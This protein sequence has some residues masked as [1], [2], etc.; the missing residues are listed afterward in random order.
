MS[1]K[2]IS[3]S[4]SNLLS[5]EYDNFVSV[6]LKIILGEKEYTDNESLDVSQLVNE[7][8]T[9][10]EKCSTSCPNVFDWLNAFEGSNEIFA[11]TITSSLSGSYSAAKQAEEDYLSSHPDAKI[12]IIDSLTAGPEMELVIEKLIESRENGLS[13]EETEKLIKQYMKKTHL[14]VSLES[15]KN[16]AKNGRVSNTVAKIAGVLGIR[17]V[18]MASEKGTLEP[19]HKCR[20][21]KKTLETLKDELLKFGYIG[22]K[23]R[24]SYCENKNIAET[25]KNI[26]CGIFP[27]CNIKIRHCGGLCSF[28]AERGGMILG[29]E[30]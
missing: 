18:G 30:T 27:N 3:D 21:E 15:L 7:M 28:Y 11:V 13:F 17:V 25:F 2:I 4:S 6:P 8:A 24:I 19:I 1:F 14:L 9:S 22:G 16:L 23:L 29:F 10:K 12:C 20:G 26:V 5:N